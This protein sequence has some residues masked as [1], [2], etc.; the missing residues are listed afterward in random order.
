MRGD[1]WVHEGLEVG[2]PPLRK[3]VADFPLVVH[4]LAREL[5]T[6]RSEALVQARFEPFKL[7][8]VVVEVVSGAV[9][10]SAN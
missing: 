1:E 8:F 5:A 2:S 10:R 3:S 7:A 4:T 9:R 6:D